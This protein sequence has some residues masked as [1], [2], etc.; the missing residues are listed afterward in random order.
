[1]ATHRERGAVLPLVAVSMLA[2]IAIAG[3][4]I[5]T[6][7]VLLNKARLQSAVDAA[8]LAAAKVLDQTGSTTQADIS[9]NSVLTANLAQYPELQNAMGAGL[10][11][12]TQ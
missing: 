4:A 11:L 7:H 3:L 5:D 10:T 6:S 8:A 9:A 2:L 12:T 1:M